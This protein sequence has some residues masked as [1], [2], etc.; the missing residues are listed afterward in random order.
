MRKTFV[1]HNFF[2][3]KNVAYPKYE[4]THCEMTIFYFNGLLKEN[5]QGT[6][7]GKYNY[8]NNRVTNRIK[9]VTT[10]MLSFNIN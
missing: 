2:K 6:S 1:A 3:F 4:T 7:F 9:Q 8:D 5:G 10:M